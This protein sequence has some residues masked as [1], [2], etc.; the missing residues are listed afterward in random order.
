MT[1]SNGKKR[2]LFVDDE[3]NVL[4][5]LRRMLRG[6][7]R[8]WDM[9]FVENGA[10]A[11]ERLSKD[12]F[13]VIISDMKMPEMD[14][15]ELLTKVKEQYPE[16]V[17]I[18]L[19]GHSDKEM[20]LRSVRSAQQ[21]LSKPCD[22][23]SLKSTIERACALR[24]ILA[25]ESLKAV[26]SG[27]ETLPSLP[28]LYQEIMEELQSGDPSIQNIGRIIEKDVGMTAKILQMVNS[29]F[30][31]LPRHI[32]SP[33]QA[34][35]LL[36][37]E[38]VKALVL[39]VQVF[40]QFDG[41]KIPR[42]FMDSLWKH[43]MATGSL[44]RVILKC[45]EVDKETADDA[46]MAALLHDIGKLILA[47][48]FPEKYQA[49]IKEVAAQKIPIRHKEQEVFGTTHAQ[50][51]AYLMGLWGLPDNMVEAIA[52]HHVPNEC[53]VERFVPLIAVHVAS[54]LEHQGSS[55]IDYGEEISRE[56]L[57]RLG[58]EERLEQWES[59]CAG[60]S[61]KGS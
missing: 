6:M 31:G 8:E 45:E 39:S 34:V 42:K 9:V 24:D 13:D 30:F 37:L 57:C 53:P 51:G 14:G 7:R 41:K 58:L 29:A 33:Q 15:A 38:T 26:I 59:L 18:I 11:L 56:H 52:F 2:I 19:S 10:Q 16:V 48:S 61:Q 23:E 60:Q 5:G 27:I 3:P 55:E 54:A 50:V 32:S 22:A 44:V 20:I 12:P 35:A 49:I 25:N 28:E 4:S 40:S 17:R 46:Y 21:Y 1:Q 47:E 43:S 36:G